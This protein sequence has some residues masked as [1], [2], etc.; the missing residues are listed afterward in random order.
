MDFTLDKYVSLL[1]VIQFHDIPVY[2]V[3]QWIENPRAKGI[4]IRHDV[5]RLP[6]NALKMAKLENQYDISSTYY[7]RITQ[8]SFKPD[9][10]KQIAGLGHEI[11]Y[12]YEDLSLA[13]GEYKEAIRLFDKHLKTIRQIVPVKTIAMHGRP[14]SKVNN[15]D[16]WKHDDFNRFDLIGEAFLSINY[17]DIYYFTDT[18]RS[19][20]EKKNNLRDFTKSGKGCQ[21][22]QNTNDLIQFI[23]A[24]KRNNIA[25]VAHPE[26]WNNNRFYW[27]LYY[28]FD[29]TVNI[30]KKILKLLYK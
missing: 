13:K 2:S 24:H 18:G 11:G 4:F 6:G 9:I 3:K 19:W 15:L 12:H 25:I 26:R 30:I 14:L 20:D 28:G 21:N 5:D 7:F 16:L 23:E 22:I 27:L 29:F 8:A 10:I 1:K 17:S